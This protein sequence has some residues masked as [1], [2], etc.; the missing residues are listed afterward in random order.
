MRVQ[1]SARWS[2]CHC[3]QQLTDFW[4]FVAASHVDLGCFEEWPLPPC[5]RGCLRGL[6][7]QTCVVDMANVDQAFCVPGEPCTELQ[8]SVLA[9]CI[10]NCETCHPDATNVVLDDCM[11]DSGVVAGGIRG[12]DVI[13]QTC[14]TGVPC[15]PLQTA[16]LAQCASNCVAC[17]R[18]RV[19]TVLGACTVEGHGSGVSMIAQTC[20]AAPPPPETPPAPAPDGVRPIPPPPPVGPPR[21]TMLQTAVMTECQ[22]ACGTCHMETVM[23]ILA[24]CQIQSVSASEELQRICSSPPP[25]ETGPRACTTYQNLL[26]THCTDDCLSC[27]FDDV[28]HGLNSCLAA[29]GTPFV[30]GTS[31]CVRE[32]TECSQLQHA[33]L[34]NCLSNCEECDLDNTRTVLASCRADMDRVWNGVLATSLIDI[35]CAHGVPCT[36]LQQGIASRCMSNCDACD[37]INTGIVLGMCTEEQHGVAIDFV[38]Q[39]CT[40]TQ[41]NPTSGSEVDVGAIAAPSGPAPPPY[42]TMLQSAIMAQC[43]SDCDGCQVNN[44]RVIIGD[45]IL[46]NG[47][48]ARDNMCT[49]VDLPPSAGACSPL[50]QAVIRSCS[51]DCAGCDQ[52]DV[53]VVLDSC[54]IDDTVQAAGTAFCVQGEPCSSVQV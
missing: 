29:D 12:A 46:E 10:S 20:I 40:S 33:L 39:Q 31:F 30:P 9:R 17:D 42:C 7:E 47:S 52:Y 48:P 54:T 44:V 2:G 1:H 23:I 37:T 36:A 27:S 34:V 24:D 8:H 53:N 25:P 5:T 51:D 11:T 43:H 49:H 19:G 21:C 4:D 6:I 15:S 22:Q 35:E 16:V 3:C 45:C 14:A 28:T 50:Q 38:Q 18:R 26:I 41:T 32:G 13:A